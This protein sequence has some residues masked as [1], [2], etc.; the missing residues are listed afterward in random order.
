MTGWL[1]IG[2]LYVTGIISTLGCLGFV[3]LREAEKRGGVKPK[4]SE[5]TITLLLSLIWPLTVWVVLIAYFIS[6]D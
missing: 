3:L 4:R 5:E 1:I 2:F 6:E